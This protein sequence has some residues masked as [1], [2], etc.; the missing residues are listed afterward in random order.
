MALPSQDAIADA[1]LSSNSSQSR[2]GAIASRSSL[3]W[4]AKSTSKETCIMKS[5]SELLHKVKR[6]PW[7]FLGCLIL[8]QL[9][10]WLFPSTT[11]KVNEPLFDAVATV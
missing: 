2:E 11:M 5:S 9:L 10:E 3:R 7:V 1:S 4:P 6:W 8:A